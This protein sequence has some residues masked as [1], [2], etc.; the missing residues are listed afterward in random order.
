MQTDFISSLL[1]PSP[2]EEIS[3]TGL[4]DGISLF[5]KRDDLIHP[6]VQGNK[7]R[8]L[9]N[10]LNEARQL[11]QTHIITMGGP[12]SNHLAATAEACRLMG[13][14]CEAYVR[15]I[16][17]EKNYTETLKTCISKG[18]KLSFLEKTPY[19]D[20]KNNSANKTFPGYFIPEGACNRPGVL[21]CKEIIE[22]MDSEFDYIIAPV[23]SG[24]TCSGLALGSKGNEKILCVN[25]FKKADGLKGMITEIISA[26]ENNHATAQQ[27]INRVH[28][29]DGYAFGGFARVTPG[30]VEFRETLYKDQD[31]NT[32]LVYT[33]KLFYAVWDLLKTGFFQK[34]AK[35]MVLHTGGIQGNLGFQQ[36]IN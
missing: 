34:G 1:L 27:A 21:G 17:E 7:W 36:E 19:D 31:I 18:M 13:F 9:K 3:I 15:G 2:Q 32:D 5:I 28:I 29:I 4:S 20:L 33:T 6:T 30:L 11:N 14:T 10:N 26:T 16:F 25:V 8:K 12:W 23:G 35:I 24:T 22:E